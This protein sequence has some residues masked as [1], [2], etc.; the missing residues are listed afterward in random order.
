ML[1]GTLNPTHSTRG[2]SLL[3]NGHF[4]GG[5]GLAGNQNVSILDF[6]RAKDDGSGGDNR[7]CKT[8]KAPVK[9]S[10]STNNKTNNSDIFLLKFTRKGLK[11]VQTELSPVSNDMLD[12]LVCKKH[13]Y[14]VYDM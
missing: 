5:P 8:C 1:M 2:L 4:A 13:Y 6:I 14:I 7:S 11:L 3:F 9:S 10:P 12:M